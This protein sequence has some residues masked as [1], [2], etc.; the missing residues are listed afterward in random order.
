MI[1]TIWQG[2]PWV[3]NYVYG[4]RTIVSNRSNLSADSVW[5]FYRN[6]LTA[7]GWVLQSAEPAVEA[8]SF[9][10][11]FAKGSNKIIVWFYSSEERQGQGILPA[12]PRIEL[13]YNV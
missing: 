2:E 4:F 7:R 5:A 10:T 12:G 9:K 11:I 13:I 6:G 1:V 8:T 3:E